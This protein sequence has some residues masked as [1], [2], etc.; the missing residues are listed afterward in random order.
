MAST[1][2]VRNVKTAT[3]DGT[4]ITGVL[5]VNWDSNTEF[6]EDGSD[7]DSSI[8]FTKA[9]AA[10][11]SG[12][13]RGRDP[14]QLE[15]VKNKTTVTA[16][17]VFNADAGADATCTISAFTTGQVGGGVVWDERLGEFRLAF[18]GGAVVIT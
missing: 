14:K 10:K 8:T 17:F 11:C 2:I 7:N 1:N 12:T 16:T 3:I 6:I 13:V 9:R 15:L 18:R 5:E 4:T